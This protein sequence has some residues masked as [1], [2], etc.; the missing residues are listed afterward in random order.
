MGIRS[1]LVDGL[2]LHLYS[3]A[4]IVADSDPVEEW[5]EIENKIRDYSIP[6]ILAD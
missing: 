5:E 4:G 1:A 6:H 2:R 3:G